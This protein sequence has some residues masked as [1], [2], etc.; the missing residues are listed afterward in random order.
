MPLSE[1]E[2]FIEV[3]SAPMAA[4]V[5]ESSASVTDVMSGSAT[6]VPVAAASPPE[7][8]VDGTTSGP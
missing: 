8:A 6:Q 7:N 4:E 3:S 2:L 5:D 1:F